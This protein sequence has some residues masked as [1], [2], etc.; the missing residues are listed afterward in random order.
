HT[1]SDKADGFVR[2][3]GCGVLVLKKL[4]DAER[5]SDRVLAVI[6]GSAVNH[7][8]A[9]SGFSAPNG[10]AQVAVIRKALGDMS[11]SSVDYVEAHGTG[12]ALGDPIEVQALASV[13]G[14]DRAAD[15]KVRTKLRIGSV[16]TNIGHAEAAAG[17]AGVIKTVLALQHELIPAHLHF[18]RP[19]QAIPW[20]EMPIEVCS[21]PFA[22]PRGT[23]VRRAAVSG[24]GAS[25]TNAHVVLEEAPLPRLQPSSR[26][27]KVYPL[28]LSAKSGGALHELASRYEKLLTTDVDLAAVTSEAAVGRSHF[29]HRLPLLVSSRED[30]IAKLQ[31]FRA[32][33]KPEKATSKNYA[34]I[35]FLFTGQ[36]AQYAGMGRHLYERYPVFREALDRCR[37]IADLLLPSPLLDA[38]F[39]SGAVLDRTE[40][41]QPAL[42]SFQF[43]LIELLKAF[44][45]S[46]EAVIGHSVGEYAAAYAAGAISMEDCLRLLVERGH[47]MQELPS[48]GK[49]VA[50]LT[51][52]LTVEQT[53]HTFGKR[54]SI[55]AVNGAHNVVISGENE[56]IAAAIEIL[57]SKGIATIP[58][59]TSH[60]FHSGLLDPM[61]D[62]FEAA[63][64][65]VRTVPPS[66]PLYSNLTGT[67]L[68]EAPDAAYWRRHARET[69]QFSTGLENMVA[70]G[71]NVLI[72]IGPKPVLTGM[73]RAIPAMGALHFVS[74]QRP[75]REEEAF[76]E[77]L[78]NLY[79]NGVDI[80]WSALESGPRRHVSLPSYPFLRS[81]IWFQPTSTS[82]TQ[83]RQPSPSTKMATP[84]T[85]PVV[86]AES[87]LNTRDWLRSSIGMLTQVDPQNIDVDMPLLNLGVDSIVLIEAAHL[88]EK[89][90]GAKLPMRRFFDDLSTVRMLADYLDV[91]HPCKP[92]F[93][94]SLEES[95]DRATSTPPTEAT[96]IERMLLQQNQI[97][98][99]QMELLRTIVERHGTPQLSLP[100]ISGTSEKPEY[101]FGENEQP[102]AEDTSA[103]RAKLMPQERPEVLPLSYAQERLWVLEQLGVPAGTYTICA[104]TRMRGDLD[105]AA[106]RKTIAAILERHESLRTRF[107]SHD[108]VPYQRIEQTGSLN[109]ELEDLS[110]MEPEMREAQV[111]RIA[112]QEASTGFDLSGNPLLRV[113]L[114]RLGE[115]EH[116]VFLAMHHIISD[117]W[118]M[119]VLLGEI[120]RFY[121]GFV[122][123]RPIRPAPLTVQYPDYALWQRK[124]L[125][126]EASE[127]Q[128]QYWREQLEGAPT[129][130]ELPADFPRTA[131]RGFRKARVPLVLPEQLY[132]ALKGLARR[133]NATPFMTLLSAFQ[134]LLSRWSGQDEVVVGTP[135]FNRTEPAVEG[136]IGF[137]VNT[138]AI[139]ADVRG[140]EDFLSLLRQVRER[141][142]GAYAHQDLP[143]EQIVDMLKPERD[144]SLQ[145]IFQ[146]MFTLNKSSDM[147]L[148][149]HG[150]ETSPISADADAA[151]FDLRLLLI[152][153]GVHCY[154]Y[155]EYAT[156]L[157]APETMDRM[158]RSFERLLERIAA[159][160]DR[161]VASI[162]L[163]SASER[164]QVLHEW[165]E[166]GHPIPNETL[167]ELFE[168]QVLRTPD[169]VALVYEESELS[170]G[171]LNRRANQ[172]AHLLRE[173]GVGPE[174]IVA[175]YLERS[176]EMVVALLAV[177]KAGGAYL[178]LDTSY[179]EERL[180]FMVEDADPVCMV[181]TG[182]A[183]EALAG[184]VPLLALDGARTQQEL[185]AQPEGNPRREQTGLLSGHP[186]YVIY[187]SG[188]T[189]RPKGVVVTHGGVC[190]HI[191]WQSATFEFTAEDSFLQRTPI[192]FDA[193]VW[194]LW[195]PLAIG[196]RLVLAAASTSRDPEGLVAYI[197]R[198]QISIVQL[199]PSLLHA[200]TQACVDRGVS[201]GC[202]LV[203]CGGEPLILSS[204]EQA[205]KVISGA[206]VNLYGPTEATIDASYWR[207]IDSSQL[208]S[209]PIGRPIW[210]TRVYVLNSRL[211]PVPVGV[212]GELYI[213]GAGLARGY[214]GRAGLTAERFVACPFGEPGSRMYRT[215][216]LARW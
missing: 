58:L 168:Q 36:G 111:L 124:W 171:E 88:I 182:D 34:R 40:F 214:L 22:W 26:E 146:A 30:A 52:L 189:G 205:Q 117:G 191:F 93:E 213:A 51:D 101:S 139:R 4:A 99:Q 115:R 31:A 83:R 147:G 16:K 91:N 41:S 25:G 140:N 110:A 114:L 156:D 50:V 129:V 196:A 181:T 78:L 29:A 154:G 206:L 131:R 102:A 47:L 109:L 125:Q 204:L 183:A 12:T 11:P 113:R 211:A 134:L 118:S 128:K 175:L 39:S 72:E 143:F 169:A 186:A 96:S 23:R 69:V 3:E 167:P 75:H 216:D 210:N 28:V 66:I 48:A 42:F 195:T 164:H 9:S 107:D 163:V 65:A 49:M 132:E 20:E 145:P 121:A 57:S 194:E 105:Q 192:A 187:T 158:A 161:P 27:R 153:A 137:F 197:E 179:P 215:G 152:D 150:L 89:R 126:G 174:V 133:E 208:S 198:H 54:I 76:L 97:L 172:L 136:L 103:G 33:G 5:D 90:H 184:A 10:R 202:N 144:L 149:L 79:A 155:L 60:A 166:T 170:Y 180:R 2:S 85:S 61:L 55:A 38:M 21:R 207:C 199:V 45:V 193:S 46:P 77:A 106:L 44:G 8:G 173:R 130:L 81:R 148:S 135:V 64:R 70:S 116:V 15:P 6:R 141:V 119:R 201:L 157:F 80:Q 68:R 160:P 43:A 32:E 104:G 142:L 73:E 74:P 112:A 7:D 159:V 127:R 151:Q 84:A 18:E 188:S 165:N 176:L 62:R 1:F 95:D 37:E 100:V 138:L 212:R 56:S 162:E 87:A 123:G 108:G 122:T 17:M 94:Q 177:L 190:S 53:I 35:A 120:G 178:P 19:S 86:V 200:V 67:V 209:I 98:T 82:V 14:R 92:S 71:F 63:A 59:N 13:Y 24:F 203:F 185:S